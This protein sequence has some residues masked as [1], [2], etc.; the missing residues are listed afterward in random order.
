MSQSIIDFHQHAPEAGKLD[1]R[2]EA[3]RRAGIV[4]A[5]LLGLPEDREPGDNA[6][7]LEAWRSDPD[8]FV[9]F[10]GG[11]MDT[12][13]P[14]DITRARDR[15]FA[16][17]K[18]IAPQR[19]YNDAAYFPLYA[20]AAALRMPTLFHLGIV[21]NTG[22]WHDCDSNLMRAIHLDH[23]ARNFPELTVVGAHF[24]NPWCD[25][26]GMACRWNPN[27]YFDLSGSLLK[28][29]KP[30]FLSELLWWKPEG[31]YASP[32]RR[33]AWQ[34]IVFGSD[35][36]NPAIADVV[37][38]YTLLMDALELSGDLRRAVWHDTA[39]ELLGLPASS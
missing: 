26:A 23:I 33:H 7:V 12:M 21:A 10:F 15:G 28:Y 34:K 37:N 5:V 1:E 19:A 11:V 39:A 14:D 35:V 27:L 17:L 29:R 2:V 38:D 30:A 3:C 24:G 31:P 25:E 20:R 6:R 18:F 16:G 32:D 36:A 22:R 4:K 9:P 13:T 8:L